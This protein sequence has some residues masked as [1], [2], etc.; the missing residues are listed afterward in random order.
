MLRAALEKVIGKLVTADKMLA[1]TAL[2]DAKAIPD[3]GKKIVNEIEKS[4][5]EL[6]KAAKALAKGDPEKAI[7]HYKYAWKYAQDALK[8]A[9]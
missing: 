4:E 3:P 6:A 2:N 8:H 7:D 5:E 1:E 9:P